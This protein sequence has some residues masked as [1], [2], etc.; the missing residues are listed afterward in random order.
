MAHIGSK[1]GDSGW[2]PKNKATTDKVQKKTTDKNNETTNGGWHTLTRKNGDNCWLPENK[3]ITE[4]P[5]KANPIPPIKEIIQGI[6]RITNTS[7]SGS[8]NYNEDDHVIAQDGH[9][10]R[11]E[12]KK[13]EIVTAK[14]K[15]I[16][17]SILFDNS[18]IDSDVDEQKLESKPKEINTKGNLS[19]KMKLLQYHH[20]HL[21]K[22]LFDLKH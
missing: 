22:L 19:K 16:D 20:Q 2:L 3:A 9:K 1:K 11:K 7:A 14:K 10:L 12:K 15:L 8:L 13:S 5:F 17:D 4:E 6:S 21:P 18:E